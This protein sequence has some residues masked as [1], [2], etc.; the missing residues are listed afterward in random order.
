MGA[1]HE[2]AAQED[3]V[4]LEVLFRLFPSSRM[5]RQTWRQVCEAVHAELLA[6]GHRGLPAL[7]PGLV[8]ARVATVL[9]AAG[10]H[11]KRDLQARKILCLGCH[12]GLCWS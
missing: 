11:S 6:R 9:L 10:Y 3:W 12:A 2:R 4:S 1:L 5:Q 7:I 8:H